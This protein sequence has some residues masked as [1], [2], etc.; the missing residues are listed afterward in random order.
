VPERPAVNE[1]KQ[2]KEKRLKESDKLANLPA[3][4][5]AYHIPDRR[6]PDYAPFVLLNLILQGDDGSRLNQRLVKE[7]QI[8]LDLSGGINLGLG[9][10]F[11]YDGP[12]LLV[13][14]TTYKT[15]HSGDEILKEV[16]AVVNDIQQHGVTTRELD[17]AKVRFRSN[18]Y[19]QLESTFGRANLLAAFA[20]FD[21]DPSRINRIVSQYEGVT[22]EQVQEVA[23]KYLV[24]ENRTAIDRL[25]EA[26]VGAE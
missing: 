23:K 15:G 22:A 19:D 14:R 26:R 16:D 21:D 9:N 10:E 13:T 8:S 5:F 1:P 18:W 4:A 20:L 2:T 17:D 25:P 3:F 24:P 12:M 7:K 11:D 6:S